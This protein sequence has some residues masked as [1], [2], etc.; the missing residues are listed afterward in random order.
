MVVPDIRPA[1]YPVS[2]AGYSARYHV[3]NCRFC[4]KLGVFYNVIMYSKMEER[5][6]G[7]NWTFSYKNKNEKVQI[8][9]VIKT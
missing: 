1:G 9:R 3:E 4:K 2:F 8:T 6:R 5:K 7:Q